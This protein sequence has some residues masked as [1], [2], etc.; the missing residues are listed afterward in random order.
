MGWGWCPKFV[1]DALAW[2]FDLPHFIS[3]CW[4]WVHSKSPSSKYQ[5]LT[6]DV[7]GGTPFLC[8]YKP[9][10]APT[11]GV[12]AKWRPQKLPKV[13]DLRKLTPTRLPQHE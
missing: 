11:G 5:R 10:S 7:E 12:E 13:S 6:D 1:L 8:K 3:S 4:L 2:I 9:P